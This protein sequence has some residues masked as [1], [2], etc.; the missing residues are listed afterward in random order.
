MPFVILGVGGPQIFSFV[1][2]SNWYDAGVYAQVLSLGVYANLIFHPISRIYG[3]FEKQRMKLLIDLARF[4]C[5]TVGFI[6]SNKL[7]L[8]P[9]FAVLIYSVITM[10]FYFITYVFAQ[11][12]MEQNATITN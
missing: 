6:L 3:V 11:R 10:I 4:G 2:G 5:I 1:F 8:K 7:G 9:Q 12:I